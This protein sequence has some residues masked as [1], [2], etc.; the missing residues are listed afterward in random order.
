MWR[1]R[2][3]AVHGVRGQSNKE[4]GGYV[5]ACLGSTTATR[6]RVTVGVAAIEYQKSWP[7]PYRPKCNRS[8][9][10]LHHSAQRMHSICPVEP[11]NA[12]VALHL[13]VLRLMPTG[14]APLSQQRRQVATRRWTT[15]STAFVDKSAVLTSLIGDKYVTPAEQA[16]R[17]R[18][19]VTIYYRQLAQAKTA[20]AAHRRV[21]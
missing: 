19:E 10:S 15:Y 5:W 20:H 11:A 7:L 17:Q 14:C 8:M 13:W 2:G 4:A 21:D 16:E 3:D 6:R 9:F 1:G 12:P 18:G